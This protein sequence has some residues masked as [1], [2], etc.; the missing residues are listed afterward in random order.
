MSPQVSAL[1][2]MLK[3][4]FPKFCHNVRL[5]DPFDITVQSYH[6]N[7]AIMNP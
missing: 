3:L 6:Y 1:E 4:K 5:W 7:C 2:K